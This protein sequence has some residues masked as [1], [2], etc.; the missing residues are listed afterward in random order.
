[1]SRRGKLRKNAMISS[2]SG[3]APMA[4]PLPPIPAAPRSAKEGLDISPPILYNATKA[5]TGTQ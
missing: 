3:E 5:M 2:D 1:M 4:A